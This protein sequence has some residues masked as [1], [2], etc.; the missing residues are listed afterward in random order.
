[1]RRDFSLDSAKAR[2]ERG[3]IFI[4][5]LFLVVVLIIGVGAFYTFAFADYRAVLRNEWMTQAI[6]VA[7]AGVDQKLTQLVL[8]NTANVAGNLNFDTGGIR[9]GTYDVFYGVVTVDLETGARNLVNP[10]NGAQMPI[11][12]YNEGDEVIVSTGIMEES[13]AE[14]ARRVLRVSVQ[15][16]PIISPQAAVTIGGVASTNG[17]ITVDG[18]EH[19]TNGNLTVAPGTFGISTASATFSQGGSSKLGGNGIAPSSPAN[20][21][22]Y[23]LNGPAVP[24]TP[25]QVLGLGAGALDQYKT[26]TPPQTPFNGVVYLTTNW[27]SANLDGSKGILIVHNSTGDAFL[28]NIKGTFKG[29]IISDDIIHI[30]ANAQLI[31]AVVGMKSEGVT[32]GNG[33]AEVKYSSAV[34]ST[35]PL[36]NYRV[37]SWQDAR[38]D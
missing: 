11:A 31:G 20:P 36:V 16:S 14:R 9:Q 19:D 2:K 38:N 37:T 21:A 22:S 23:E 28:K 1:M 8:G 12:G 6:F 17:S 32:I 33:D 13:G 5:F 25:E 29:L 10:T 26:S 34:L 35:L 18:R 4:S 3:V 7:E 27:N 30:N 24:S 15:S